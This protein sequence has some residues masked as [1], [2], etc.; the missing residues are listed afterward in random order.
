MHYHTALALLSPEVVHDHRAPGGLQASQQ[1][2]LRAY[3]V[4]PERLVR[5]PPNH[6]SSLRPCGSTYLAK[7]GQVR[8]DNIKDAFQVSQNH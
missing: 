7:L 6:S 3:Q 2:L 5:Q 4:H 1:V 8:S